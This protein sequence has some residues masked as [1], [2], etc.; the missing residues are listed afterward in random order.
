MRP[1]LFFALLTTL[2]LPAAER[3]VPMSLHELTL[4][5]LDGKPQSL[6]AYKGKVVLAVN[7][8]SECGYTPQYAGLQKLHDELKDRGFSV[9]GFPSNDFANQEPGTSEE[10]AEFCKKNYGVSFPMFAKV[11]TKAG[12]GQSPIY[13]F[14]GKR[15]ELPAWNFGK[16]LVGRDG[17][18]IAFYDSKV[19]PDD[20]DLRAAIEQALAAPR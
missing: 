15:G 16:Y 13:A 1:L 3:K 12:E 7:V 2:A 6:A 5:T 8:A 18:P 19:K 10:I 4:N 17:K 14:L 9:L 11:V 20:A